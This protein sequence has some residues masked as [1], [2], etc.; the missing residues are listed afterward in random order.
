MT[1][2]E[3]LKDLEKALKQFGTYSYYDKGVDEVFDASPIVAYAGTLDV[4]DAV[5]FLSTL[6]E[7]EHGEH[8]AEHIVSCLDDADEKWFE[9]VVEG[10]RALGMEVY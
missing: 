3:A 5:K 4:K 1:P 7:H 6:A 2:A 8:L 10:C 9:E